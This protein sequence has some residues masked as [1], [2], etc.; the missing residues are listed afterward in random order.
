MQTH[1]NIKGYVKK[2]H[3]SFV[4]KLGTRKD[5]YKVKGQKNVTVTFKNIFA[6]ELIEKTGS[7]Y[8]RFEVFTAVTMKN[9]VFWDVELC[10]SCVKKT[11]FFTQF[12]RSAEFCSAFFAKFNH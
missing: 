12:I 4:V 3:S 8:E 11:A 10:R 1:T 6:T 2:R 9:A 7:L 5:I